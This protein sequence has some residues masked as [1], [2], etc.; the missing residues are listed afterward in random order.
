MTHKSSHVIIKSKAVDDDDLTVELSD[1]A[2]E[3]LNLLVDSGLYGEN[4]AEAAK[5]LVLQGLRKIRNPGT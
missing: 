5:E 3:A 4:A 2:V 1:Q